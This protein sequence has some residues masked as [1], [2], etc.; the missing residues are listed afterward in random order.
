MH[1]LGRPLFN[2]KVSPDKLVSAV[3]DFWHEINSEA[4][5]EE[6][7]STNLMKENSVS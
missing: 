3:N 7:L 5:V 4:Y 6:N 2:T 1:P